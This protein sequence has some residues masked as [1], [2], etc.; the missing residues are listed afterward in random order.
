MTEASGEQSRVGGL[1]WRAKQSGELIWGGVAQGASSLTNLGLSLLAGRA[2]GPE[3]LGVVF[4][5]FALYLA[6]LGFARALLGDPLV[7]ITT[8]SDPSERS[9]AQRST[10]TILLLGSLVV[11]GITAAVGAVAS[12]PV[13]QGLIVIAPWLVPAL[14]QDFW[15]VVLFQRKRGR[16]GAFNDLTWVAVMAISFPFAL[17]IGQL[18][19]V[20]GCWGLGATAG[21]LLGFIQ[22]RLTPKHV[23][24]SARWWRATAWPMGRWLGLESIVHS[25]GSQTLVFVLAF[26]VGA[27]PLGGLRSVQTV[28][29]PLSLIGAALALPALPEVSRRLKSSHVGARRYTIRLGGLAALLTASYI[30]LASI[31]GAGLLT[32]VFGNGFSGFEELIWPVGVAQLIGAAFIGFP[33]LLKGLQRS[34]DLFGATLIGSVVTLTMGTWLASTNGIVGAAWGM[35]IGVAT[36][37]TVTAVLANRGVRLGSEGGESD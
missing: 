8:A 7:A 21:A 13:G 37:I 29:A 3:G 16:S 23:R 9:L 19:A 36:K 25:I 14:L 10:L 1:L 20:V 24:T 15:R 32:F 33:I 4:I 22:T 28:Y 17:S 2:L 35:A 5:G 18:W 6:V 34:R 30:T 27:G 26:V 31:A 11:A 12:H